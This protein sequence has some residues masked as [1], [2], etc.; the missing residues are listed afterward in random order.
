MREEYM[1]K[2]INVLRHSDAVYVSKQ[3]DWDTFASAKLFETRIDACKY[4]A[5]FLED[6][7][8]QVILVVIK[9]EKDGRVKS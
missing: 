4:I 7:M 3:D 1:I 9:Q 5:E 8:Y 2:Q 6:G